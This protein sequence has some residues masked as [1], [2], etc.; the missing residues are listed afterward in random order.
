MVIVYTFLIQALIAQN[1]TV[2]RNLKNSTFS[3][4]VFNYPENGNITKVRYRISIESRDGEITF[5]FY[6]KLNGELI[7]IDKKLN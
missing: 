7:K 2:D 5:N 4:V 3:L 6:Y 1:N